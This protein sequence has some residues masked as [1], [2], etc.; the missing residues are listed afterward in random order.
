MNL[1]RPAQ[2]SPPAVR[3]RQA[4][5]PQI[6]RTGTRVRCLARSHPPRKRKQ[7]PTRSVSS[8]CFAH[9]ARITSDEPVKHGWPGGAT[10]CTDTPHRQLYG[11]A[12]PRR[13]ARLS[14]RQRFSSCPFPRSRPPRRAH[15]R[16]HIQLT[17][18]HLQAI[19]NPSG[20][21]SDPRKDRSASVS[22]I[23]TLAT[24]PWALI[25]TPLTRCI[26]SPAETHISTVLSVPLLENVPLAST[27]HVAGGGAAAGGRR[28]SRWRGFT[29]RGGERRGG[30]GPVDT[31]FVEIGR[32]DTYPLGRGR[33]A[34]PPAPTDEDN[35]E[36]LAAVVRSYSR[37]HQGPER[38]LQVYEAW[39][40]VQV[41]PK[42]LRCVVESALRAFPRA[43][44]E[45]PSASL[46]SG[47]A[48]S[49]HSILTSRNLTIIQRTGTSTPLDHVP[50]L[51]PDLPHPRSHRCSRN[52]S[53]LCRDRSLLGERLSRGG[54]SPTR[55]RRRGPY[56]DYTAV[57][58][59]IWC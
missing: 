40:K 43:L 19:L 36:G 46:F 22:I 8:P 31:I 55:R 41:R 34:Y 53:L 50:L 35:E 38:E 18:P 20:L 45:D 29:S 47:V 54:S 28:Q 24:L 37:S 4:R 11:L 52:L 15:T 13:L 33:E 58:I 1:L 57:R 5:P 44:L 17:A 42:G 39:I 26:A 6:Q 48:A 25:S 3:P 9:S 59:R 49:R 23:R 10:D 30:G 51:L 32:R 7:P 21:S 12:Q 2:A 27:P 16:T 14:C 56:Q